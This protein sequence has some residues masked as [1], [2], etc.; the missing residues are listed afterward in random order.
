MF[1]FLLYLITSTYTPVQTLQEIDSL[2]AAPGAGLDFRVNALEGF[3]EANAQDTSLL[4]ETSYLL[5]KEYAEVRFTDKALEELNLAYGYFQV[6][7]DS[8]GMVRVLM[9]M[10]FT[11]SIVQEYNKALEFILRAL[12][13]ASDIGQTKEIYSSIGYVYFNLSE[14]D[15]AEKYLQIAAQQYTQTGEAPITPLVNLSGVYVNRR[16]YQKALEGLLQVEKLGAENGSPSAR[17]FMYNFIS[18]LYQRMGNEGKSVEYLRKRDNLEI[19]EVKITKNLDFYETNFIAD[20]LRGDYAG[21]VGNQMKYIDQYKEFYKN[22]L[23]TQLA[24]YQKLFELKEK[25][26]AI[27]I[28]EKEN[29]LYQLREDQSTFYLVI[30]ALGIIVLLLVLMIIYRS[31]IVRTILNKKLTTLNAQISQQK[32]DLHQKNTLL[33]ETIKNLHETQFQLIQ[34]EKMASIGAFVSGVAHELNN[35]INI[36]SGGLQVIER[37][38]SELLKEAAVHDA[39]L[40]EDVN[41]MLRESSLSISKIN[42]IIQ[43]LILATYTDRKPVSVSITEIIDNVRLGLN[44]GG[45]SDIV[46]SQKTSPIKI[47]CFPNRLHHAIK[48]VLEN[49]F[50]YAQRAEGEVKTVS[51]STVKAGNKLEI[52]VENNG[53]MIPE[54]DLSKIFDPFFTTKE[55]GQ[56]PGLGLYFAF[57]ATME[58]QGSIEAWNEDGLVVFRI[59]LPLT[60]DFKP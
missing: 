50:Y 18:A 42:R 40:L 23:T 2:L 39:E 10:S 29:Q 43:A 16:Q 44:L 13:Y 25:E 32:E 1:A 28:L 52:R 4:A 35:P 33:E 51:I 38:L 56:S 12:P 19:K 57:S 31:L 49:A 45:Y 48:G 5:G 36:V 22:N 17:Y 46:F 9:M 7:G 53:P 54:E 34:S 60:L 47:E 30:A 21:A 20:T 59:Q 24:N 27:D 41:V 14:L 3:R 6:E 26:A 11:Y 8:I 37:N 58:H 15:S 55:D